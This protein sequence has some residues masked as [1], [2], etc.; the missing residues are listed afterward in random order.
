FFGNEEIKLMVEVAGDISFAIDLVEREKKQ[1]DTEGLLHHSEKR[2]R[3]LIEHDSDMKTLSTREGK[4]FYGSPS[5]SKWLGYE[6]EE[7]LLKYPEDLIHPDDIEEYLKERTGIMGTDGQSF[8]F[9][10]RRLHK[11][12]NWI[13]CEGTVTN[14]LNEPAIQA[15]VSNFTDISEKVSREMESEFETNN[16]NALINNTRDLMWSVDRNFNLITSNVPFDEMGIMNFGRSISKGESVLSAAYS[17]EMSKHFR[18]LYERAFAGESFTET[19]H[20]DFP[21]ELWTEISY[22]PIR[23]GDTVIGTACHSRDMTER[24]R[25]E[26]KLMDSESKYRS[27]IEQ[28]SDAIIV[29]NAKGSILEINTRTEK[30]FGYNR[31]QLLKMELRN[32]LFPT[33]SPART[34]EIA[35]GKTVVYERRMK[36]KNETAIDVEVSARMISDGSILGIFRDVSE[37][38]AGE[39][40]RKKMIADIA[41][42]NRDLEQFT[43]IISHNLRAPAANIIGFTEMLQDKRI[44]SSEQQAFLK[45]L[46]VSV[47]NLDTVIKDINKILEINKKDDVKEL[48]YFS[49]LINDIL[50]SISNLADKY[51][52]RIKQDFSKVDEIYSIKGYL[53]SIFYNLIT[54]SI[55]YRKPDEPLIIEI[56]SR[57]EN[58]TIIITFKDNGS[59]IDMKTKAGEVFK[60]YKRFHTHV[61]GKGMGL[62]MVKTQVESLGGNISI[63]SELNKGTQFTI[64]FEN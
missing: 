24:K 13:W 2:Y 4:I 14:M 59:G 9:R 51:H 26:K 21:Y 56:K 35:K 64:E 6:M 50:I 63:E 54:N 57:K 16:L 49:K 15:M 18:Q 11:N 20:F 34:D 38:K 29:V 19:E 31:N 33:D 39:L 37:R 53:H 17:T 10:Q 60:L 32:L 12:G 62:F 27:L 30:L 42:R 46:S 52:V 36:R 40:E 48:V 41:K 7:F 22:Y 43:F 58:R 55:K 3:A 47:K 5:I 45:G 28:A 1:K 44:S 23:K 25:D 8:H 61:E